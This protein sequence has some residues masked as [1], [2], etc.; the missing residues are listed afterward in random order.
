QGAAP[1]RIAATPTPSPTATPVIVTQQVS[2]VTSDGV[3]L[4]G[5]LY[6]Q[7]TRAIILSNEGDNNS[8]AWVPMARQL[9]SLGYLVLGYAY[10]PEV[11]TAGLPSQG[12]R[13]LQ[14]AIAF[15]HAQKVTGITLMGSSLGGLISLKEAAAE[16]FDA[17]VPISAPVAF[18][19]VQLSD[20]ELRR[21]T[22]PKLFV[23][24]DQ[25]DPFT[26][27]TYHMFDVTP[28][29]KEERI[30]PGRRHG[31]ALFQGTSDLLS[32]LRQ[33]LQRYAP[34]E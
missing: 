16:H 27:D 11:S 12:L 9:A 17:L 23:T 19:D 10:R 30:Y 32:T 1:T 18:E 33:F 5:T 7:G 15:M 31:L 4:L 21:I 25:N 24:S 29:P 22:T 3:T 26:S 34:V 2:F 14:A 8:F 13:D 6:G 28:Q 20:A